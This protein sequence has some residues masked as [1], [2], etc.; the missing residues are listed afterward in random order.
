VKGC[1]SLRAIVRRFS[2]CAIQEEKIPKEGEGVVDFVSHLKVEK[3]RCDAAGNGFTG[4]AGW[5]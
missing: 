2:S 4:T 1:E 3:A 5:V